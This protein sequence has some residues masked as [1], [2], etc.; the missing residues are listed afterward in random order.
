MKS[1]FAGLAASLVF[2]F[3]SFAPLVRADPLPLTITSA[4]AD[5]A[6]TRLT[7]QGANF[8]GGPNTATQVFL[9]E[10][11]TPL[12]I[13]ALSN[14]EITVLLPSGVAPGS[15]LLTVGY[16]LGENRKYD[17]MSVALGAVGPQGP[18]GIQGPAGSQGATGQTGLT[19]ATGAAGAAGLGR[20]DAMGEGVDRSAAQ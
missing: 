13:L 8:I 3:V 19:G 5:A 12:T 17:E 2:V 1:T 20:V 4:A 9:G 10:T 16:G 6:L 11:H 14:A 15:Y 18:Q 7:I